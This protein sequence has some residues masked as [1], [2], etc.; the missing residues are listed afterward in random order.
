MDYKEY[1]DI[2]VDLAFSAYLLLGLG[3]GAVIGHYCMYRFR[4]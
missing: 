2:I 4:R 1:L 3:V